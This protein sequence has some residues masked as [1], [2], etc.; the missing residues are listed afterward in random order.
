MS[1]HCTTCDVRWAPFQAKEGCCPSCGDGT[2]RR[3]HMAPSPGSVELFR[4]VRNLQ[5]EQERRAT[6][7][8]DFE[9]FYAAW[10]CE[11][12]EAWF[13]LNDHTGD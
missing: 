11:R 1:Y 12:L 3:P 10:E 4:Q 2:I 5:S 6:L 8:E 9:R 7:E 13:A